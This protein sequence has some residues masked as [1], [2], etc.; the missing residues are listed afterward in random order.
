M[1]TNLN[2]LFVLI[3]ALV[4]LTVNHVWGA[5]GDVISSFSVTKGSYDDNISYQ[6][7]Q[8]NGTSAPAIY[9]NAIRLYQGT[10]TN[11]GGMIVI[12]AKSGY[13]ITGVT[14]QST[15][16][17]TMGYATASYTTETKTSNFSSKSV[18]ANTDCSITG[19]STSVV[20]IA[21]LGTTSGTRINLSKLVVTYTSPISCTAPTAPTNGSFFQSHHITFAE[22]PPHL[23]IVF[24]HCRRNIANTRCEKLQKQAFAFLSLCFIMSKITSRFALNPLYPLFC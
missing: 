5:S 21:C 7:Y 8:G 13:T 22:F 12:T 1:K 23:F 11:A 6:S 19:L 10:S 4:T 18:T 24:R 17:T 2:R 20:T 16:G 3:F 14:I 15:N 9:S